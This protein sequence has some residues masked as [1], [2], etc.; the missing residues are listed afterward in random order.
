MRLR[1]GDPVKRW[2]AVRPLAL[3]AAFLAGM[4]VLKG[5]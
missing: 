1:L 2:M 3:G 4:I 5:L